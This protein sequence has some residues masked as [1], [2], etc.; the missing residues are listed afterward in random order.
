MS[1]SPIWTGP[2]AF[3]VMMRPLSR[4]SRTRTLTCVASPAMPVRPRISTTSE[5]MPSSAIAVQASLLAEGREFLRGVLDEFRVGAR[6]HDRDG[7]RRDR[8]SGGVAELLLRGDVAV[9][10]A[11]LFAE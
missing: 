8:E 10:D 11:L 1:T 6:V 4:P 9:G 3:R 2:M 7:G 5:G